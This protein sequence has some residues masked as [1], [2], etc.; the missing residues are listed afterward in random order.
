MLNT[1]R[2]VDIN[3]AQY[4]FDEM[5]AMSDDGTPAAS[6]MMSLLS[7]LYCNGLMEDEFSYPITDDEPGVARLLFATL[8]VAL[9]HPEDENGVEIALVL[10]GLLAHGRWRYSIAGPVDY[11]NLACTLVLLTEDVVPDHVNFTQVFRAAA[12]AM[13]APDWPFPG[14]AGI[15]EEALTYGGEESIRDLCTA[16]FGPVWWDVMDPKLNSC[17]VVDMLLSTS[18]PLLAG[19]FPHHP[20]IGALDLP[21]MA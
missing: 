19:L 15:D 1:L 6:D 13:S 17:S 12:A 4:L 20:V 11:F 7:A 21:A 16:A 2:H 3:Q 10:E 5:M 8:G 14:H 18:P 9:R